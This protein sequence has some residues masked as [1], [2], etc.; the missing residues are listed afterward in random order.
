M[1]ETLKL[2]LA[3]L[4]ER[5]LIIGIYCKGENFLKEH[6][7]P[8]CVVVERNNTLHI[9]QKW[10]LEFTPRRLALRKTERLFSDFLYIECFWRLVLFVEIF[11]KKDSNSN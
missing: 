3:N 9:Y 2:F 4:S 6:N 7:Y 8:R 1:W 11:S 5:I 10:F